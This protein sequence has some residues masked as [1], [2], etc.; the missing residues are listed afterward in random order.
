MAD[1]IT[2]DGLLYGHFPDKFLWGAATENYMVEGG[3]GADGNGISTWDTFVRSHGHLFDHCNG[4]IASDSYHRYQDDIEA[5][6][7]IKANHYKF[8]LSWS[9]ILPTGDINDVNQHGVD[10]YNS[11]IDDL[12]QADIQ[13]M[14]T[15]FSWD[16]PINLAKH[17]GWLVESTIAAFVAYSKLCFRLFGNRVKLWLTIFE[18]FVVGLHCHEDGLLYPGETSQSSNMYLAVHNMIKAHAQVYRMYQNDFVI[19][20][21]GQIGL[22]LE[23]KW[24]IMSDPSNPQNQEAYRINDEFNFGWLGDPIFKTGDYPDVV[25]KRV[26]IKSRESG[27]ESS[28]LPEFTES[29]KQINKGSADFYGITYWTGEIISALEKTHDNVTSLKNDKGVCSK[30]DPQW[31]SC[32]SEWLKI[33]PGGLRPTLNKIK[34]RFGDIPI[35]V[36]ANGI[37]DNGDVG[38]DQKRIKYIQDNT[39]DILKAICLDGIDVRGYTYWSLIDGFYWNGYQEKFGLFHVDFT[40]DEKTRT[41]KPSALCFAKIV[42]NNGF[43]KDVD[44]K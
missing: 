8:S 43:V 15:L 10:Y 22:S 34:D 7:I 13:P 14:V 27:L 30:F 6:K 44:G 39:N 5:L 41:A 23:V 17:G 12:L 18:P 37:S 33:V 3:S 35:Y 1:N 24:S 21:Q 36:T 32:A 31:E 28:R 38:D 25:K 11:L 20:Q 26:E 19:Q 9:R 4:D 2:K 29:E 42:E 16:M 40:S